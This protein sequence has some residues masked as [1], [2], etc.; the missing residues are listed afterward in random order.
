MGGRGLFAS[1]TS[2]GK[3]FNR[4]PLRIGEVTLRCLASVIGNAYA[5][6][7]PDGLREKFRRPIIEMAG[8][9]EVLR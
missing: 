5:L 9:L 6:F 3:V 2:F 1:V 8:L 4:S 7:H